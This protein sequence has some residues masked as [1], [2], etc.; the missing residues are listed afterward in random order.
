MVYL[1]LID[2]DG[3]LVGSLLA[4]AKN[5]S[6]HRLRGRFAG[7]PIPKLTDVNAEQKT[8]TFP[9]SFLVDLFTDLKSCSIVETPSFPKGTPLKKPRNK[10]QDSL[11]IFK[12]ILATPPKRNPPQK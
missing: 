8:T 5:W 9:W 10:Q 6:F 11:I 2:F 12:G 4:L 1:H 7:I 3:K